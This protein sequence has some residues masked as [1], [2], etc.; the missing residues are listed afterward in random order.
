MEQPEDQRG[1]LCVGLHPEPALEGAEIVQR[2]VSDREANDRVD[3]VGAD[4]DAYQHTQKQGDRVTDREHGHIEAD[5]LEPVE[6]EDHP[7][8]EQ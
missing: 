5:V 6:K 7:E 8:Q 2:L 3:E 1:S 4:I